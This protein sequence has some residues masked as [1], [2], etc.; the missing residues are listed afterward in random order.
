MRKLTLL[1]TLFFAAS[2]FA[3]TVDLNLN[4]EYNGS[5]FSYGTNY[6][7]DGGTALN[8]ERVQYYVCGFQLTHD[9]GQTTNV[10]DSYILASGNQTAYTIGTAN[11]TTIEGID[12]NFGVDPLA[13]AD[14]TGSYPAQ[15][16]LGPKTPPMDWGWPAGYFFFVIDGHIDDTGD[17]VPN[18]AFQLRGLGNALRRDVS[19]SGL[20]ITGGTIDMYV[21]VADWVKNLDLP[22]VGYDHSGSANNVQVSDNTNDETVFTLSSNMTASVEEIQEVP[23]SV[24]ANYDLEYA[25]TLFYHF[26][27]TEKV[28]V[29]V[30]DMSGRVVLE[31]NGLDAEGNYFIRK[32]LKT[33]SYIAVF[34]NNELEEKCS[35]VVRN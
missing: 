6:L 19:F 22:T 2:G 8:F 24:Y 3:Q 31:D 29:K 12:F 28:D 21:N 5:P 18:K 26:N 7:T 25:P 15:H 14:G 16:P 34:S 32:E 9:G 11:V 4:H 35:F 13:N 27:T 1:S 30:F 33:G 17:G 10:A 23:N 20:S